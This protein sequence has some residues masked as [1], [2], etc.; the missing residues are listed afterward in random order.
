[1]GDFSKLL[2]GAEKYG[3]FYVNAATGMV[4][5]FEAELQQITRKIGGIMT[6]KVNDVRDYLFGEIEEKINSF[7]NSIV[8]EEVKTTIW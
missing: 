1:M 8:P 7:T 3:D 2:I 4:V 6:A 5:N